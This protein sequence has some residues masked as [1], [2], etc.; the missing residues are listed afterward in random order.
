M[1]D[2]PGMKTIAGRRLRRAL[3]EMDKPSLFL[4]ELRLSNSLSYFPEIA[5]MIGVPQE[6]EW[7]PEG[8]VWTHVCMVVDVAA[9][10]KIELSSGTDREVYMLAALCHDLGKP[11]TTIYSQ[12]RWR[13]PNHDYVGTIPAASL[14]KSLGYKRSVIDEVNNY[15]MRHLS[16]SNLYKMKD[17][18]SDDAIRRL[19]AKIDIPRLLLLAKADNFGRTLPQSELMSYPAAE[20]LMQRYE[21][22][23]HKDAH[24]I[25]QPSKLVTGRMLV[26]LGLAPGPLMGKII[27]EAFVLQLK[28]R[29]RNAE[30]A[31][32]WA[33]RRLKRIKG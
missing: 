2:K 22:V 20:W 10:L 32:Q 13:S 25:E 17:N 4:M 21:E 26:S 15:V 12:G 29:L 3:L 28:G 8:D 1:I 19:A 18:V 31:L 24:P 33:G 11:Y 27:N 23:M 30:E 7:H 16:P 14:L 6:P 5:A 9:R